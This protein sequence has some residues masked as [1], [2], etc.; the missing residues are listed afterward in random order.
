[1]LVHY[2]DDLSFASLRFSLSSTDE[3]SS[4]IQCRGA[5]MFPQSSRNVCS[6]HRRVPGNGTSRCVVGDSSYFCCCVYTT[7]ERRKSPRTSP[8]S[9]TAFLS[10]LQRHRPIRP[11]ESPAPPPPPQIANN[12]KGVGTQSDRFLSPVPQQSV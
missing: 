9:V 1:M 3:I 6:P 12:R 4:R 7:R 5:A 8:L 10:L 2:K 11:L